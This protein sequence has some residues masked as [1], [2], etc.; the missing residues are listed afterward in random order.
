MT[1]SEVRLII[2][3]ELANALNIILN[4]EAGPNDTQ[5]ETINKL[6]PGMGGI[7]KRPVVHPYGFASRAPAGMISVVAK[8]G[9]D[10]QNRMTIGHRAKDRP[11]DLNSGEAVLYNATGQAVYVRDGKV[12]VGT[13]ESESP[14]V[15][16]DVMLECI[17]DILNAFLEAAQ[18][19]QTPFGPAFLDPGVRVKLNEALEK[20]VT[21]TSTNIVSQLTFT[22]RGGE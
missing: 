4:A 22:E 2:K 1:D 15:L 20:Y 3:Q 10:I 19:G 16:G 12:Q 21:T 8:V 18:I 5:T 17:T 14:M 6:F 11:A 9:A 13:K 7:E